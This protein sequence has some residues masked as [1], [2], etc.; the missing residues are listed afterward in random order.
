MLAQAAGR[1]NGDGENDLFAMI[2]D[3]RSAVCCQ[4]GLEGE[5][6]AAL[7]ALLQLNMPPKAAQRRVEGIVG[8]N[9]ALTAAQIIKEALSE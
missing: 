7:E 2:E 1:T 3:I 8:A 5:A 9:P 6:G 4:D